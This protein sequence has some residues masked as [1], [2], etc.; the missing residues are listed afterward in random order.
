MFLAKVSL[1]YRKLSRKI[2]MLTQKNAGSLVSHSRTKH[3]KVCPSGKCRILDALQ[4][5][6]NPSEH[7]DSLK[8]TSYASMHYGFDSPEKI[9]FFS[10]WIWK[11]NAGDG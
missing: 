3:T 8:L 11:F 7:L 5:V 2:C 9:G 6:R 10:F 4:A 1:F